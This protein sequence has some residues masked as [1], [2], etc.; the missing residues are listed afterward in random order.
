MKAKDLE[1]IK[2]LHRRAVKQITQRQTAQLLPITDRQVRTLF[3]RHQAFGNKV[4]IS[5][6][7]RRFKFEV[8]K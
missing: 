3:K 5:K 4:V 1:R 7:L 6:K 2:V 8:H